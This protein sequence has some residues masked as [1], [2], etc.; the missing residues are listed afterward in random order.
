MTPADYEAELF[1]LRTHIAHLERLLGGTGSRRTVILESPFRPPK[2]LPESERLAL[3]ER[4][5]NYARDCL[6][7]SL[8]LGEAPFAS[9][10]LF[11]QVL[12]DE[13]P[14]EREHGIAAGLAIG[15]RLH[16]TVVYVNLGISEGMRRG[17]EAATAVG[18]PV[19]YRTLPGWP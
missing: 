11:T 17:I 14:L 15:E 9:H 1:R 7:H 8:R 12:N 13:L 2:G 10:L 5:R 18:R 16:A 19:E 6:L 3:I 4:N